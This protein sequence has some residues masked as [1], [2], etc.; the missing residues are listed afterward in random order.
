MRGAMV[1]KRGA[2]GRRHSST[3]ACDPSAQRFKTIA[4]RMEGVGF[5]PTDPLR[6]LRFSKP[7]H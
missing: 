5:E 4:P 3:V 1:L 7:V 2:E 6:G